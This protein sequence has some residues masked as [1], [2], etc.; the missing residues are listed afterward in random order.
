MRQSQLSKQDQTDLIKAVLTKVFPV[1]FKKPFGLP[2]SNR[3]GGCLKD[4]KSGISR[5]FSAMIEAT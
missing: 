2:S 3:A 4:F 5:N 1:N